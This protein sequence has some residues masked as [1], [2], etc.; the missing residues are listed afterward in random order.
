MQGE[1][2]LVNEVIKAGGEL[3][4]WVTDYQQDSGLSKVLRHVKPQ[5]VKIFITENYQEHL[6]KQK[7]FDEQ[8]TID[9]RSYMPSYYGKFVKMHPYLKSG[10]LSSKELPFYGTQSYD[11]GVHYFD[12]EKE[13]IDQYNTLVYE[14]IKNIQSEKERAI[15]KFDQEVEK[16]KESL[17]GTEFIVEKLIRG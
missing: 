10:K 11:K 7:V 3:E 14:K 8:G 15:L 9:G 17:I 4:K 5:L 1:L 2:K 13:A 12:T 16:L 6:E